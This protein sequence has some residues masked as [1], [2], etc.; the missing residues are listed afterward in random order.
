MV[1]INCNLVE[2]DQLSVIKWT[3]MGKAKFGLHSLNDDEEKSFPTAARLGTACCRRRRKDG[4]VPCNG[5]R[6]Q[7]KVICS[8][9]FHSLI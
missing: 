2:M 5:G 9:I 1:L 7:M 4:P 3:I 6:C 8:D